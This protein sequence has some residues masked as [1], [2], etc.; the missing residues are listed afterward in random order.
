MSHVVLHSSWRHCYKATPELLAELPHALAVRVI[1]VT[2]VK[3]L[4][5]QSSIEAY[6]RR[7]RVEHYVAIDD[8]KYRFDEDLPW[9]VLSGPEGLSNPFHGQSASRGARTRVKMAVAFW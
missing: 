9:L 7:Y 2:P 6:V 8:A 1:G 4:D 3:V 5:R